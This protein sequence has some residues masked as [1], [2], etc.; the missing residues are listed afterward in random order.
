MSKWYDIKALAE[1]GSPATEAKPA[2]RASI[3]IFDEIGGWGVTAKQ[4]IED[5]NALPADIPIDLSIHSPG[6]E[7]FEALAIYHVLASARAR[8]TARVLGLAASAATLPLMAAGRRTAAANAYIMVHNPVTFSWGDAEEMREAAT[9]L[10]R[11]TG[12]LANIYATNTGGQHADILKMMEDETWLDGQAAADAGFI[13]EV[14][15]AMP[16]AAR[17]SEPVRARFAKV[18]QALLSAPPSSTH[19]PAPDDG[20]PASV[21][22]PQTQVDT[23]QAPAPMPADEVALACLAANEPDLAPLMIRA[24][25]DADSVRRRLNEASDIRA[26][27]VAAGRADDAQSLIMAGASVAHA[28]AQ[29]LAARAADVPAILPHAPSGGDA[30]DD[31]QSRLDARLSVANIYARRRVI[32]PA[33]NPASSA[34]A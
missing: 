2:A 32:P 17:L 19:N 8:L 12:S 26:L 18:P 25:L 10:D 33:T 3:A 16:V 20:A 21:P 29:L 11:I 1:D 4:F 23:P 34:H 13:H 14:T 5:F 24:Q 30:Q 22:A 15:D 28:R 7:V 27:A 6:G 9:L 31:A